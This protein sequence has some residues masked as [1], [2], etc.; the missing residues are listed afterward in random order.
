M[1]DIKICG[2]RDY[3]SGLVAQK[4]G[5]N[6]LGFVFHKPSPRYIDPSQASDIIKKL[7]KNIQSP[8]KYVGLIVNKDINE[9]LDISQACNLDIIQLSGEESPDYCSAISLPV[10]KVIHIAPLDTIGD[11]ERKMDLYFNHVDKIMLDNGG[12]VLKGGTGKTFNWDIAKQLSQK[13][14][15]FLLAGGLNISNISEAI[16]SL[17][18]IGLDISSGVETQGI[19]DHDKI[20]TLL[21]LTHS[22]QK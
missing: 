18:P 9:V 4:H 1:T 21:N 13:G 16:L 14:H 11:I 3:E 6:Y 19:K 2:I 10:F 22:L 7:R 15:K 12:T 20:I 8:T 17:N 5:A